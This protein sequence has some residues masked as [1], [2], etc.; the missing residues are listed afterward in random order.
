MEYRYSYFSSWFLLRPRFHPTPGFVE[1]QCE[2]TG[3][4]ATRA[5]CDSGLALALAPRT[6][7]ELI[8]TL[9]S[10]LELP[11]TGA[12]GCFASDSTVHLALTLR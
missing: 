11:D 4:G 7:R 10:T 3:V 9:V 6:P 8:L 12:R 2:G 5:Y 1:P